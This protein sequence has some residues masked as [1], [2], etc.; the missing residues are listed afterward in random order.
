MKFAKYWQKI[1][2]PVDKTLFGRDHVQVWGA[3]NDNDES[4]LDNARTRASLFSGLFNK[5]FDRSAEYEY[6]MGYIREEVIERIVAEDGRELAVITR[7]SYGALV[8]NTE[9]VMFGDIDLPESGFLD[10]IMALLGKPQKDKTYFLKRIENYQ[11]SHPELSIYVY[12]T[13]A[14]LR[15]VVVNDIYA[16]EDKSVK[17]IFKALNVDPLYMKLCKY[18]TCFRARLTAKPWR[19]GMDRPETRFPRSNAT[20]VSDFRSWLKRY[21]EACEN[22]SAVKLLKKFGVHHMHPDVLKVLD[23]HD[24]YACNTAVELA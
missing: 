16:A 4:A 11:Q 19:V 10:K 17:T 24:H 3:S 6:W 23:V 7:N 9:T 15:F 14:G 2:V 20:D 8:L 1:E 21:N 13:S 22:T 12:E 5:G 18:Q